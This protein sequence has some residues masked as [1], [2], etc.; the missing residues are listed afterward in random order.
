MAIVKR[1]IL[2]NQTPTAITTSYAASGIALKHPAS[3][4][5]SPLISGIASGLFVFVSSIV[6]ATSLSVVITDDE[7]GD[8]PLIPETAA[9]LQTGMTT[10]TKGGAVYQIDI[11]VYDSREPV[12]AWVKTN[13]GSLTVDE[14]ILTYSA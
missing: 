6:S 10:A 3:A 8:R 1:Q 5:Q 2:R 13:T 7:A 14:I 12:F 9:T 4:G 11:Q